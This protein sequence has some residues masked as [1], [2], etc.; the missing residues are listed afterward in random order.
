MAWKSVKPAHCFALILLIALLQLSDNGLLMQYLCTVPSLY[1]LD[2]LNANHSFDDNL[3]TFM[4]LPSESQNISLNSVEPIQV[5]FGDH[6]YTRNDWDGAPVVIEKF[7]LI[8]FTS[9]K[10]GCTT[11]KQ[12]FRRI[13]GIKDWKAEEYKTMLPWNPELNGLTYLYHY[14]RKKAS[15]MM[16]S[17]NWTRAIF[18]RDPKERFYPRISIRPCRILLTYKI[19]AA[20]T[21]SFVEP[22][23]KFYQ[24]IS[25]SRLHV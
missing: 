14:N 9:A 18:V 7:R 4:R 11:W 12:L 8:F 24:W 25:S 13:M 19:N 15:E 2:S 22:N 21:P 5:N 17:P 3:T 16:T 1:G 10:V 20:P 6:I 23:Q